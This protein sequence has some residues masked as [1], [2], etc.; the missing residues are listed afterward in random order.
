MHIAKNIRGNFIM[1]YKF[2]AVKE[3]IEGEINEIYGIKC[4]DKFYSIS[5]DKE[6]V[7][8]IV[9]KFNRNNLSYDNFLECL[10]DEIIDEGFIL[11]KYLL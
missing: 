9:D 2:K 3:N 8:N 1:Y 6:F 7:R 11:D 10:Y 4:Y 5:T